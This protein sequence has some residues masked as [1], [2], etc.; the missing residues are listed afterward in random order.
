VSNVIREEEEIL[1]ALVGEIS[2]LAKEE[3]EKIVRDAEEEARKII[4]EAEEKAKRLRESK[5][6]QARKIIRQR[7]SREY[8]LKRLELM[9]RF[10]KEKYELLENIMNDAVE[11]VLKIVRSKNETYREALKRLAVES[12]LNINSENI[13]LRVVKEDVEI[14]KEV[15]PE[16]LKEVKEKKGRV[17][18]EISNEPMDAIGGVFAESGDGREYFN[19]TIDVRINKVKEE[20]LPSLLSEIG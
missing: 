11:E 17:D 20:L 10:V 5:L 2:R 12:S 1:E 18:L 15:L 9:K 3:A 6:E 16:I 14:L 7:L 8:S 13:I 19:N 4:R